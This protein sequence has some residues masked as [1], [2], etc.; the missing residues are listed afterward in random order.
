MKWSVRFESMTF[1]NDHLFADQT[2]MSKDKSIDTDITVKCSSAIEHQSKCQHSETSLI[3][4]CSITILMD[5]AG[6]RNKF[7]KE[8][9]NEG[10][11]NEVSEHYFL[12]LPYA[13]FLYP[14]SS[15]TTNI[16]SDALPGVTTGRTIHSIRQKAM[17][18]SGD[19]I[20]L[21]VVLELRRNIYE[22]LGQTIRLVHH[23]HHHPF[24]IFIVILFRTDDA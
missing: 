10:N 9:G 5:P 2:A 20:S 17:A 14:P 6:C 24:C 19:Q 3:A 1:E 8:K 4:P 12:W 15:D 22:R 18:K 7:S 21:E 11:T 23:F 16:N 13:L